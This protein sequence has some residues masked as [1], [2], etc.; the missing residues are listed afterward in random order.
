MT[1][2]E[3]ETEEEFDVKVKQN[4][5]LVVLD[6]WAPWCGPCREF[7]PSFETV[8]S[9]FE[10][11]EFVKINVDKAEKIAQK[12]NVLGI[13][14]LFCVKNGEIVSS[15]TGVLSKDEFKKWV[16]ETNENTK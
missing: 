5:K 12:F 2:I 3:V 11:V 4:S 7:T 13:P 8:S 14:T 15:K 6:F 9:E 16:E 1:V 10:D